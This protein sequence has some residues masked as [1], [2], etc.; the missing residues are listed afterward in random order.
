MKTTYIMTLLL[1]LDR[2]GAAVFFNRQDAT[3]SALC[4]IAISRSKD[5]RA[6]AALEQLKPYGWQLWLLRHIGGDLERLWPGHC[7]RARTS[8]IATANSMRVLLGADAPNP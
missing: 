3:I 7:A 6:A 8:D 2:F 5:Y 4:W 1:A